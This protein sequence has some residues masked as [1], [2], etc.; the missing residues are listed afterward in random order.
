M[1]YYQNTPVVQTIL[2]F[3]FL[4][5]V[6]TR[7][8]YLTTDY[9][10]NAYLVTSSQNT[11]EKIDS[12]GNL[13]YTYNQNLYGKL[14]FA[15]A[16]NPLKIVLAYP[17]YGT[18]VMLDNTLS[19][20]GVVSLRKIGILSFSVVCF[21]SR[22]NNIWVFD[23]QDYKLKKVDKNSNIILESSDMFSLIGEAIHPVYM[24]EQDQFLYLTDPKIGII[25]FDVYG[26]YYQTLPF[27]D[28]KKFQ[29]R[30]N[31]IFYQE[32]GHLHSYHLK[33]LQ[34]TDL[35]LPDSSEVKDIRIEQNRLYLLSENA[36]NI[37]RY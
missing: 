35:P 32:H 25:I 6:A 21:S 17:E 9:L 24:Q 10:Q 28:I 18:V 4:S 19:E 2:T 26:T 12:L 1:N 5:T 13:L 3:I 14:K 8:T 23:D 36:L 20:I 31:Q 15:D 30:S 34:Q 16:T 33:T 27:K 7:G 37:Y 22:D 11:L 29:V